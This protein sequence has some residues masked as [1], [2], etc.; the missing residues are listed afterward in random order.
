MRW[1]KALAAATLPA[2]LATAAVAVAPAPAN[3]AAVAVTDDSGDILEPGLD[4]TAIKVRNT[5][6]AVVATITFARD[7]RSE[8]I[9]AVRPRHHDAEM[10]R[11][12]AVHLRE[13]DDRMFL[14]DNDSEK[15]KCG[16]LRSTWD[17]DAATM[18]MR[19]PSRCVNGGD[20]GAV[21]SWF[22][23]EGFGGGGDVD[24]APEKADGGLG[25]TSWIARG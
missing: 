16:G 24:Y 4:F 23:T 15:V 5:D 2:L 19:L 18:K 13:G 1:T 3:A 17:R 25:W 7:R 9:V 12:V 20:Y 21:R 10:V 8:I 11:F 6:R 14:V 22:L